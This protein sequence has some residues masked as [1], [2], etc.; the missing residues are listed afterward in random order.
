[1]PTAVVRHLGL[2]G[3][4]PAILSDTGATVLVT[5]NSMRLLGAGK[6]V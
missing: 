6:W 5:A 1:M 3:L 4:W 2:T